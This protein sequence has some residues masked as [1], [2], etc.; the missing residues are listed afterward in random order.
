M[1]AL[2]ACVPVLMA[3]AA[4]AENDALAYIKA[5][6]KDKWPSDYSMQEYCIGKQVD[7]INAVSDI[8][9]S[10]LN[11]DEKDML[12]RCMLKWSKPRGADWP[13][14]QYCYKKQHDSYIR[15]KN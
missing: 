8:H 12:Q 1:R 14:V 11:E 6:C 13:M 5:N 3:T 4:W 7:A 9:K 15:L 10:G 2:L